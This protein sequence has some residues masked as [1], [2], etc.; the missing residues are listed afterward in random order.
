M[1]Y[2]YSSRIILVLQFLRKRKKSYS[3]PMATG[4]T[5]NSFHFFYRA[6]P[7]TGRCGCIFFLNEGVR[8]PPGRWIKSDRTAR[9]RLPARAGWELWRELPWRQGAAWPRRWP[10]AGGG[11]GRGALG[12]SIFALKRGMH[13]GKTVALATGSTGSGGSP[14]VVPA[15]AGVV[16]GRRA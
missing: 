16:E 12:G 1:S 14:G 4:R 5:R 13:R 9:G 11:G 7:S 10:V 3:R 2:G 8:G 6:E 15:T